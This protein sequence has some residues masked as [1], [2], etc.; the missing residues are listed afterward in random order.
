M[1]TGFARIAVLILLSV[2][3]HAADPQSE[4]HAR[5]AMD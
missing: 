3:I 4:I 1:F 5:K 2:A